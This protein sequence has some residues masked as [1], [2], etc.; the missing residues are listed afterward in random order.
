MK[1]EVK[2]FKRLAFCAF[3]FARNTTGHLR[4]WNDVNIR[5][6]IIRQ[7]IENTYVP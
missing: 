2:C 7:A 6:V 4:G 1:F 3:R 5:S